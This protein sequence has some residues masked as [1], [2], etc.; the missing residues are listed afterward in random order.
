M[1]DRRRLAGC[2]HRR[3]HPTLR[4]EPISTYTARH[5]EG[6]FP[7][8]PAGYRGRLGRLGLAARMRRPRTPGIRKHQLRS[9]RGVYGDPFR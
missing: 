4:I 6:D 5:S 1:S 9:S 2:L 7:A 3:R 8:L